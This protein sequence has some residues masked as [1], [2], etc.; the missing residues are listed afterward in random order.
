MTTSQLY[1]ASGLSLVIGSVAFVAQVVL[2]SLFTAGV[3][4]LI[5]AKQ[6]VWVPTNALGFAGAMLVMMGL[7]GMYARTAEQTGRFGL[8]GVVLIAVAWTFFG[9]F[10]RGPEVGVHSAIR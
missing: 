8:V 3:D 5:F 4:P 10:L 9:V 6:G 1:R 2:R 7:P